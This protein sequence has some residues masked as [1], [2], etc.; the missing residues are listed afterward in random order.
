MQISEMK[1]KR[2]KA[3]EYVG[4]PKLEDKTNQQKEINNHLLIFY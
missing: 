2:V 4:R 1:I 3:R